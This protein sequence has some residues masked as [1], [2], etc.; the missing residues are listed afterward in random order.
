MGGYFVLTI[1]NK[2]TFEEIFKARLSSKDT[3]TRE[4]FLIYIK[5]LLYTFAPFGFCC[6]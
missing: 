2:D 4:S 3:R 5:A 1:K 6:V